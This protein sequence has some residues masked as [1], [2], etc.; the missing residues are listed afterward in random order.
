MGG[1]MPGAGAPGL[2]G[3]PGGSSPFG[4]PPGGHKFGKK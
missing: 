3:L 1:L 4:L 2:P